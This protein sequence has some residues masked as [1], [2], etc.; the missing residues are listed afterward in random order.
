VHGTVLLIDA[1]PGG[2]SYELPLT[3][4]QTLLSH[5]PA[6]NH[7]RYLIYRSMRA[8]EFFFEL[9]PSYVG[10]RIRPVTG[11]IGDSDCFPAIFR[12]LGFFIAK[13]YESV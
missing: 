9:L 2:H 11:T 6:T 10:F 1:R 5:S 8:F 3:V 13:Y 4:A 7:T 12:S